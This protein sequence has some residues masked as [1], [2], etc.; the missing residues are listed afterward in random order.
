MY[1]N[2]PEIKFVSAILYNR[3]EKMEICRHAYVVNTIAK[4]VISRRRL[5][6]NDNEMY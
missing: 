3:E 2:H 5:D 6:K 1:S 4:Q